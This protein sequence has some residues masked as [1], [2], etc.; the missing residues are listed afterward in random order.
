MLS[1]DLI[2]V[3]IIEDDES[4]KESIKEVLAKDEHIRIYR[5][6]SIGRD[7]INDLNSPF[8]PDVC[9]VDIVL[10]DM[11]G[12]DCCKQAKIKKPNIHLVLMTA[13]P[14]PKTFAEAREIGADYIEKG[15]RMKAFIKD[16][17]TT[18]KS[19]KE[20]Q[21]I[22]INSQTDKLNI[23]YLELAGELEKVKKNFS[24]LSD[25]QLKVLKLKKLGKTEKAIA[26]ILNMNQ[27]TVHTHVKRAFKKLKIPNLLDY[28]I[29]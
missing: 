17:I 20:E 10:G 26:E 6:Y 15:P 12:V 2:K 24:L 7:F 5:E 4:Y 11:S 29:D 8:Q 13:Y 27:G 28:I 21:F 14:D 25:N 9:L 22:S 3:A 1:N 16:I 19:S 23:R 18:V